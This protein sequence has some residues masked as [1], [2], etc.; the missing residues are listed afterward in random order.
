MFIRLNRHSMQYFNFF[1]FLFSF[2]I[3]CNKNYR[4]LAREFSFDLFKWDASPFDGV[5]SFVQWNSSRFSFVPCEWS[6]F[7]L[8]SIPRFKLHECSLLIL[9]MTSDQQMCS[10]I[11]RISATALFH[12]YPTIWHNTAQQN[13]RQHNNTI[14]SSLKW[15]NFRVHGLD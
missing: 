6:D 12:F 8:C 10:N 5:L 1:F 14:S 7:F 13:T 3:L 11:Y 9:W 2:G 4:N 15:N